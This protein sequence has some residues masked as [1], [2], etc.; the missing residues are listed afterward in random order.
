MNYTNLKTIAIIAEA[1]L[2]VGLW[3]LKGLLDSIVSCCEK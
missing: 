2:R 3:R 1:V